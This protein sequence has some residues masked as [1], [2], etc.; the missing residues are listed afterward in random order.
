[1]PQRLITAGVL[2]AVALSAANARAW[3]KA[4]HMVT[5]SICY[6]VLKRESP[7]ALVKVLAVLKKHPHYGR[8]KRQLEEF[9]RKHHDRY[10]L[11]LAARWPDDIRGNKQ[12]DHPK[13]HYV[14]FPYKPKGQPESV[15][16]EAP[17][18]E[19][20]L[21]ALRANLAELRGDGDEAKRAVA[22]CWV[23]HLAGDLHMPLH[24]VS[25]YTAKFP[26]G[27]AGASGFFVRPPGFDEPI[28]L[29]WYWDDL[30]LLNECYPM[31]H[32][33]ANEL[34][35]RREFAKDRLGELAVSDYRKWAAES[36]RLARRVVYRG[37]KIDGSPE[38]SSAP[39]LPGDYTQ[40]AR[41]IAERR[42]VLAGYRMAEL[43]KQWFCRIE[44]S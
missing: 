1:M 5:G 38:M 41:P 30:V 29:H 27:D 19:N 44:R 43:M 42:V 14:D 9:P 6:T 15:E 3:N 7:E 23:F 21:T 33:R 37:G 25:L 35:L 8:W 24:A 22:L 39:P 16:A 34:L 20:A 4:G 12:Y 10:L 17:E 31:A 40:T 11:M 28:S 26:K 2:A 32:R 13:W 36:H 18:L